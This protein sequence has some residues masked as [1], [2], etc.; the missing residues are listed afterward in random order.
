[1]NYQ[2][3]QSTAL[4]PTAACTR[5]VTDSAA[6]A[7]GKREIKGSGGE[8]R[9]PTTDGG[10]QRERLKRTSVITQTVGE[11]EA[12]LAWD[13]KDVRETPRWDL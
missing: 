9:M 4:G 12:R 5:Y 11:L 1:M 10:Q 2:L 6:R 8:E 3:A 13:T 7:N